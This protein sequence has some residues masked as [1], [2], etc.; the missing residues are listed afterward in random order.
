MGPEDHVV[1]VALI[2]GT[3]APGFALHGCDGD[4]YSLHES[5]KKNSLVVLAFFKVSCP[6]CQF[7][8]PYLERLHR[9]YPSVPIWGISQDDADATQSFAKMFGVTFPTLLDDGLETTVH[10]DLTNVPSVF[11]VGQDMIIKQTIV[12]FVKA[13]LEKLNHELARCAGQTLVP[14]FTF[15]DEVPELRPG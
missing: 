5:L 6:V 4:A 14:L 11:V 13:E 15:A 2:E 12:G 9:S 8:F 10:Y 3:K 1:M 7:E